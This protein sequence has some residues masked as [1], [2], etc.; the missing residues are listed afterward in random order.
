MSTT[1]RI[2]K[3]LDDINTNP[4]T[5]CSAGPIDD[6]LYS[7]R[8]S[9]VGPENSPYVDG[10]F[11]LKIDFPYDYPFKPPK[12]SFITKI[13]HCN[14]N[15]SGGICL[16]ILKDEW[17]PAL[18]VSKLLLSICSLMDD[19]NPNDPLVPEIANLYKSDKEKHNQIA[20]KYTVKYATEY[21][22]S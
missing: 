10:L 1:R 6:N 13:Y 7:W 14:I 5:N 2:K 20:A 11:Y 3:E 15:S 18:T 16:D 22:G 4:P 9:I 19:P 17:S 8:A 21:S 12:I